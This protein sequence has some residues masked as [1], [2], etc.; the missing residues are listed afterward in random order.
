MV[1]NWSADTTSEERKRTM[2]KEGGKENGYRMYGD[3]CSAL[4]VLF[5]QEQALAHQMCRV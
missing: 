5:H 3:T 4:G 1:H 2:K